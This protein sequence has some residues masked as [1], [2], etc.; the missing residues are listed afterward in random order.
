MVGHDVYRKNLGAG[1]GGGNIPYNVHQIPSSAMNA[2]ANSANRRTIYGYDAEWAAVA[3]F[4]MATRHGGV[5]AGP[6]HEFQYIEW[7]PPSRFSGHP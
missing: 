7:E 6:V 4:E 3:L 5:R 2:F 1:V